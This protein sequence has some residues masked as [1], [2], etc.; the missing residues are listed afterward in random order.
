MKEHRLRV[1][2]KRMLRRIFAPKSDEV[3]GG[4]RKLHNDVFHNFYSSPGI[5]RLMKSSKM[6]RAGHVACMMGK[7]NTY[8]ILVGKSEGKRP[9]G[10]PRHGWEDNVKWIVERGWGGMDSI[11]LSQ[12]R[13]QWRALVNIAVNLWVSCNDGKFLSS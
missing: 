10:R 2:E 7:R 3:R 8:R 5:I 12:D 11:D 13:V 1:F 4:W 6:R 9:L